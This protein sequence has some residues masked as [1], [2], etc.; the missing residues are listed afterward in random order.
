MPD[1]RIKGRPRGQASLILPHYKLL[2]AD[3]GD[4]GDTVTAATVL[5]LTISYFSPPECPLS[6]RNNPKFPV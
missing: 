5:P 3:V 4:A 2:Q 1:R 6:L